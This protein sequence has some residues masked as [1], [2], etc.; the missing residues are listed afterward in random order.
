VRRAS[1]NEFAERRTN[2]RP[3]EVRPS[4]NELY[5]RKRVHNLMNDLHAA[6]GKIE[7]LSERDTAVREEINR[8]NAELIQLKTMVHGMDTN[9]AALNVSVRQLNRFFWFVVT[10]AITG[11]LA[12][13]LVPPIV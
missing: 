4:D 9:Q 2:Q 8:I 6:V 11:L 10:I 1:D 5:Q 3:V 12:V 7:R 13:R